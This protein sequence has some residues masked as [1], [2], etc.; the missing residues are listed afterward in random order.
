MID[1]E[2][3]QDKTLEAQGQRVE[4]LKGAALDNEMKVKKDYVK[5]SLREIEQ[6][7]ENKLN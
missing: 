4:V 5:P 7:K 2:K 6:S 1:F 3:E